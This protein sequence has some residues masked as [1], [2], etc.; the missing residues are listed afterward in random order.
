LLLLVVGNSFYYI[1]SDF[2][3]FFGGGYC[4]TEMV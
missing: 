4:M 2:C 3:N 1:V